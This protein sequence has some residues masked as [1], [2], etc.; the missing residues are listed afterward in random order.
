[1]TPL[2]DAISRHPVTQASATDR[3]EKTPV[4]VGKF[5]NTRA[6][7]LLWALVDLNH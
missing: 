3:N 4:V 1:M 5:A 7:S 6:V 2:L